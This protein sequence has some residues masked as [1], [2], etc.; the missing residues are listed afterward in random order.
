M[1]INEQTWKSWAT[2][3]AHPAEIDEYSPAAMERMMKQLDPFIVD[4]KGVRS[5]FNA[6]NSVK[7]IQFSTPEEKKFYDEAWGRYE[8]MCQKIRG[9]ELSGGQSAFLILAQ[10][11]IFR[12][13]A[14]L[15]RAEWY[16]DNMYKAVQEGRAAV[17]AVSFKGTIRR[18]TTILHQKYGVPRELISLIWGGGKTKKTASQKNKELITSNPIMKELMAQMGISLADL[19]VADVSEYVDDDPDNTISNDLKLGVQNRKDRQVEIDRF[20]SGKS[21][22][23]MFTFKAGGVGLSL[24]HSDEQTKQKVRRTRNNWAMVEDIPLIPTRQRECF[25]APTFSAIELV[26]G[27]GRCPRLTSLSDTNQTIVFYEGTIE[28]HVADLVS[29][30]LKCLRKV[31]RTRE[32]WESAIIGNVRDEPEQPSIRSINQVEPVTTSDEDEDDDNGL[33]GDSVDEEE[34]E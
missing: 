7:L 20:Q 12:K 4:V 15:C 33:F 27:L 18:V 8:K 22:Y 21:L 2:S 14:E 6:K 30:K 31:V 13:A 10:F 34:D 3:I 1:K 16:A 32:S 26:Q 19:N 24:H 29:Q 11:T 9:Y 17:L 5:Q 28:Q 25:L 23:C